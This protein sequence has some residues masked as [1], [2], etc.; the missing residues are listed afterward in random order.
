M[1]EKTGGSGRPVRDDGK[2][3]LHGGYHRHSLLVLFLFALDASIMPTI[4]IM[5]IG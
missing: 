4:L 1:G 3:V 5:G 2:P